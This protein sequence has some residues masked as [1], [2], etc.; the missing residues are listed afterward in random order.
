MLL[1]FNSMVFIPFLLLLGGF[2][3]WLLLSNLFKIIKRIGLRKAERRIESGDYAEGARILVS[4]G[5]PVQAAGLLVKHGQTALAIDVLVE[6]GE[7]VAAGKAALEAG[8]MLRAGELFQRGNEFSSAAGCYLSAGR[9]DE[10]V[11]LLRQEG[12]LPTAARLMERQKEFEVAIRLYMETKNFERVA[13]L[14]MDHVRDRQE[15][16]IIADFLT[17]RGEKQLALGVYR[18]GKHCL[19]AGRLWEEL[20]KPEQ[21]LASYLE[22]DYFA[23]AARVQAQLGDHREAAHLYFKAGRME[24]AVE[25]LKVA[26]ELVAVARLYR[27]TGKAAKAVETLDTIPKE[28]P[29]YR[30]GMLMAGA[31]EVEN[32]RFDE[33]AQRL[34]RLLDTVGYSNENMEIIYRLVDLHIQLGSSDAAIATLERAK[35]G[36]V[37]DPGVDEQLI[38]LRQS[39]D[40]FLEPDEESAYTVPARR[41]ARVRGS[42]TTIGFPRS[43]RYLLKRKLAR[44]GH[45]ILFLVEDRQLNRDVVLKLLH[46]ES[47]PSDLARKYFLREARTAANREH[48]NIVRVFDYGELE[49]RPYIAM[50]FVDGLNLIE[51]QESQT[52][53]LPPD[54]M[55]SVCVQLCGALAYAHAKTI[56]HRDI[57]MENVM[58]TTFW[59][60]KL[61]DFGL[62][63][64][65]NENPD[66]SLFIIGT[67]FYMSPEQIV[68]DVLDHRTDLYSLGVLM[69][70][71][72]TGRL[73]FEEGEVLSHHRFTPPPDP[74][75]FE[76]D[77]PALLAETIL[78]CLEKEREQRFDSASQI[79]ERL[80]SLQG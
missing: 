68:G 3:A 71:L 17:K 63:K 31:I 55:L 76:P 43:E 1:A 5:E 47:L 11:R 22:H 28:S 4:A 20:G 57:K 77:L 34:S 79:A 60:V 15:L 48:Q 18:K 61:M 32:R 45:G 42:T 73:P 65:L 41:R 78:V 27:R 40:Y 39:P 53:R 13:G 2:V 46:S 21:A 80:K 74:R 33:S 7:F 52:G 29:L 19:E 36:G 35:R 24:A 6:A 56:I 51:L 64:A 16:K 62:A 75:E 38:D 54:R 30:E 69:F 23:D 70:R 66:R 26:G 50:E 58:V 72:F 25:E 67:P 37:T 49:G 8:E 59:Q 12:D 10:A 9:I 44:G 14:A